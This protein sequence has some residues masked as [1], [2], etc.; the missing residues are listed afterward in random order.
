[1]VIDAARHTIAG[2]IATGGPIMML[3]SRKTLV[4]ATIAAAVCSAIWLS[5]TD[6]SVPRLGAAP[7]AGEARTNPSLLLQRSTPAPGANQPAR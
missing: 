5:A 4:W 2:P 3:D 6:G 1:M 7:G